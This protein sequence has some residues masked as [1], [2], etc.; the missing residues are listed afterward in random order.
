MGAIK[1]QAQCHPGEGVREINILQNVVVICSFDSVVEVG[2]EC[3]LCYGDA[4]WNG[5]L[6]HL[7]LATNL[8]WETLP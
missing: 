2:V 3:G 6:M 7:Q 4:G 5:F 1:P 8:V